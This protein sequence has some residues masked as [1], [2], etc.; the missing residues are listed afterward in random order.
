MSES[1]IQEYLAE[2]E[3]IHDLLVEYIEEDNEMKFSDIIN[4]F[5]NKKIQENKQKFTSVLY[6]LSKFSN[7]YHR[8]PNFFT[9]LE[10]IITYFQI[11]IKRYFTNEQIFNIFK[12]NNRILLFLLTQQ[13]LQPYEKIYNFMLHNDYLAYFY[14]EI[15][16]SMSEKMQKNLISKHPEI[17][18]EKAY[19]M[20]RLIGENDSHICQLIRND[21]IDEFVQFV[22]QANL[23][24]QSHIKYSIFE[25]NSFLLKKLK[26]SLIK[27]AAFCG[28]VNIFQ[29]LKMNGAKVKPSLLLFA[30]HSNSTE[31]ISIIESLFPENS[32]EFYH[33][34]L[35]EAAKCHHNNVA[36]HIL[37]NL[38]DDKD[39]DIIFFTQSLKYYNFFN[40]DKIPNFE[41]NKRSIYFYLWNYDYIFLVQKLTQV[42]DDGMSLIIS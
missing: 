21:S 5:E 9:K 12:G 23:N 13:I 3:N 20:K 34:C 36:T 10:K 14:K 31:M 28:S 4:L 40:L 16:S 22:T 18:D 33:L 8:L 25:T 1:D 37:N 7:N 17:L 38:P 2:I 26:V 6:L 30:I 19:E 39:K 11:T 15:K 35:K 24:T 41:E 32:T 29:Y 27:Y 42:Q